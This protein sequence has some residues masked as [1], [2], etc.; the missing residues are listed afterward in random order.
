MKEF[1][2]IIH[3]YNLAYSFIHYISILM[4]ICMYIYAKIYHILLNYMYMIMY[5]YDSN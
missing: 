2:L 3:T 5:S 4:Y 1:N